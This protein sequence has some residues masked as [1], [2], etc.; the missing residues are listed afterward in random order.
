[1]NLLQIKKILHCLYHPSFFR[2]YINGVC[3]LFE[4]KEIFKYIKNVGMLID[5]GSNK[6]QFAILFQY[7]FPQAKIISFEPQKEFLKIQKKIL[8][9]NTKFYSICLG[10]KNEN[11]YLNVTK[12][13][14]SSS[15]LKPNILKD[16]IYKV[17]NKMKIKVRRLD[18]VLKIRYKKKILI[19]LDVQG[20]EKKVLLGAIKSLKKID[21]ILIELSSSSIYKKQST[22]KDIV[23][24]LNKKNFFLLK[25]INKGFITKKIYQTDCLFHNKKCLDF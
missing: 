1:M 24:Y 16:S 25:E 21:Y 3:P 5:V 6:G 22:K 2:S 17:I 19:K 4:I 12:K 11:S 9:K 23:K 18:D 10:N 8:F 15:I 20:Y 14:D 13:K 7:F